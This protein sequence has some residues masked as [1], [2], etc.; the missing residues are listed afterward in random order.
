MEGKKMMDPSDRSP[1]ARPAFAALAALLF[2]PLASVGAWA[3]DD[4][5]EGEDVEEITVTGTQIRGARI[6]GALPVSVVD[7][8]TIENFGIDSGDELLDLLPENGNNF[9]NEAENISG[10]VNSARGD[11]G[12]FNLRS[13]GTGNTLVLLNGRRMV[14]AAAYQTEEVGGSFVPVNTA[15]S[16]TIP[17]Y[18][19]ERVEVLR[20]GASAIYG[21]DAVAGVV[22][23]VIKSDFEGFNIRTRFNDYEH[24]PRQDHRIVLEWGKDF[25]DG[26]TNVSAFFDYY[27]R[28]R[29]NSQDESKWA[30]S[31]FRRFV[32]E[33]SPW[34][35]D[36][37]FRNDSAN[38]LYG[39]YDI[40]ASMSGDPYGLR[41][42]G[43]VDASGEFETY[44]IGDER[45]AYELAPGTCGAP[46]GQGTFRYN[47]NENRDLVSELDRYNLF[48]F[49]NHEFE[50]GIESFSEIGA[51]YSESNL[52]R[53]PSASFSTV[54]LRVP[55]DNY[56]NPYGVAGSP[57]RLPDVVNGVPISIPAEGLELEID[58]YR[59][60]ELPRIVDNSGDMFRLLQGFRGSWDTWDWETAVVWSR[61][62]RE[63]ITRN[64]VSNTLMVEALSD[65]TPAAYNPFS[66]GVNS[67]IERALVD[68]RRDNETE[69]A[70]IDFK[71]STAELFDMPAGPA[72]FLGGI[73]LREESF[74]DDRDPRLDGTIVFTDFQGDTYPFVSDVV[75]SSPTPDSSGERVVTS[76]FGELLL[77]LHESLDVQLAV[78]YED[79]DDVGDT[80]VGKIAAGWRV[81]EALLFRGSVSTGF[82]APNLV[83]VNEEIVARQNTRTDYACLFAANNGG[84]P[85]Q[86][87]LDCV[88]SV[89]RI[90]QGSDFLKPEESVNY[91]IGLVL[92]PVENMTITADFWGI[93]KEDT[94][95]LFGE[96]NHTL[97][98]LVLAREAGTA[99][100]ASFAGNPAVNREDPSTLT[101][102]EANI[103]LASGICPLGLIDNIDDQYANLDDRTVTG[104]DLGVYYN[105]D[106]ALG[107]FDVR[108]VSSYITK[109]EQ[110]AGGDAQV[111]VEA[112]EAGIIPADFPVAGFADLIRRDGNQRNRQNL[113]IGWRSNNW[114]ASATIF[115]IS[116]FY[117]DS[118]TLTDGTRWRVPPMT[119][120]NVRADYQFDLSND[121]ELRTRI[122]VNNVSDERAPLADR[123]FGFFAD[124]HRD[125][126][127]Y[128]YLDLRLS[129]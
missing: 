34:F 82:R 121:M 96:E 60:A 110:E 120:A 66:G 90:A 33:G 71:V 58:N 87:T 115:R 46:D 93:E 22:N 15:N 112:K 126:G 106:T 38:S 89:Q 18:G 21:A 116:S 79:F 75:N 61:A 11:V 1:S 119:T 72:G 94:I 83:T 128:Y 76:L 125:L 123:F 28:D 43:L 122:G 104:V 81:N 56:Y 108:W 70:M 54:R 98:D 65:T 69:L 45:C 63:D 44:P 30:D 102:D 10:G 101:P 109:Y 39:Q 67:N 117:Q 97:L 48:V 13:L 32:P 129:L 105:W 52:N 85:D 74:V 80:T 42:A 51:Y 91:S 113:S 35:G 47:L 37:R 36:T 29:V 53:H 92:E 19:L 95:G 2:L 77:P 16:N 31:D 127:R 17:V 14:N 55:G 64:R 73:E 107:N 103:Y 118:L 4:V 5:P 78:R 9:F 68:V 25:N 20:E 23:N 99:N 40:R 26:R 6:S 100:C 57:N 62:T 114:S 111:L 41:A 3:Q 8:E 27:H 49:V 12:A 84:D 7:T 88:N 24:V 50:N 124:A 86:D 59:F